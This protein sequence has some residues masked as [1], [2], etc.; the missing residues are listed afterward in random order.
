[1]PTRFNWGNAMSNKISDDKRRICVALDASLL[2]RVDGRAAAAGTTR[3]AVV[4]AALESYLAGVRPADAAA[5]R[6]DA[7]DAKLDALAAR[8]E[9]S[10]ASVRLAYQG[11]VDAVRSQPVQVAPQLA[12]SPDPAAGVGP[13]RRGRL[14]R[15]VEAWRG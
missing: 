15:I 5:A 2:A 12:G 1:M 11:V 6:L 13:A 8:A 3:V 4:S 10:E 7:I 14:A 9:A